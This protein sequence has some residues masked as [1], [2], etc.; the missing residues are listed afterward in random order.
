MGINQACSILLF[1]CL[2]N[3]THNKTRR[4]QNTHLKY[5]ELFFTQ[6]INYLL[7]HDKKC[8]INGSSYV[9]QKPLSYMV[10]YVCRYSMATQQPL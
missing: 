3:C 1:K 9:F 6:N 4:Q 7:L 5:A 8:Q 10:G 2:Q